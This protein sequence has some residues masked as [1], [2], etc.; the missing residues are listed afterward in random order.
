MLEK[1]AALESK[2]D[3]DY[4]YIEHSDYFDSMWADAHDI[5]NSANYH[6]K[7]K[8]GAG[9][10]FK[11]STWEESLTLVE[12]IKVIDKRIIKNN[13][14]LNECSYFVVDSIDKLKQVEKTVNKCVVV[15]KQLDEFMS[16]GK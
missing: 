8:R 3:R 5:N 6:Y 1:L 2:L 11:R 16:K 12:E 15:L 14:R 9:Y 7:L 13:G 10:R 4:I